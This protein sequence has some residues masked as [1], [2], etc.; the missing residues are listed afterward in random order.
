MGLKSFIESLEP[1]FTK[2]GRFE[3]MYPLYE[4]VDTGLY[5]PPTVTNNSAHVRDGID[6]K[7]IMITV[8]LCVHFL[9]C[10]LVCGILDFKLI[11]H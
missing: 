9:P 8:W 1:H 5:S 6:L 4:A 10:S 11:L 2:G 7:R 3:K